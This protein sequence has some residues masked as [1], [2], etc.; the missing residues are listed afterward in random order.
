MIQIRD[1][2]PELH[3]EL[4]RRAKLAGTSLTAYIEEILEREI[5]RPPAEEVFDRIEHRGPIPLGAPAADLIHEA[6]E[7]LDQR[8]ERLWPTPHPSSTTSRPDRR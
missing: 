5:E 7:E 3:A 6:R 1:V 2:R 8:W 4:M